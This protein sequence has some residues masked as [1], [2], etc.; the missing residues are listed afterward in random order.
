[1]TGDDK[2]RHCARCD[3]PVVNLSMLTAAEARKALFGGPTQPCTRAIVDEDGVV[4]L[5]VERSRGRELAV[6]AALTLALASS[7][8]AHAD[9]TP[10]PA[11]QPTNPE[12]NTPKAEVPAKTRG[13]SESPAPTTKHKAKAKPKPEYKHYD[14]DMLYT[15]N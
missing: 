12:Q 7:L 4:Q 11:G 2:R 8:A 9:S 14:G 6:G 13:G 5:R 3:K 10:P 15:D 1:M